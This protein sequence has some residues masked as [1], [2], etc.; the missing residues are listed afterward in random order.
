MLFTW[1]VALHHLQQ[2]TLLMQP[3]L[4]V[5]ILP[6]QGVLDLMVMEHWEDLAMSIGWVVQV[7]Y[8][9]WGFLIWNKWSNKLQET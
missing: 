2:P 5:K 1:F 8:L 3:M 6:K 7:V 4:E 9:D